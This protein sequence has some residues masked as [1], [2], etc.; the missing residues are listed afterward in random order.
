LIL[1]QTAFNEFE[2]CRLFF[3]DEIQYITGMTKLF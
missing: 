2:V 1:I 3:Q